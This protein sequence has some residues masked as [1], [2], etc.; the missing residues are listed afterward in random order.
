MALFNLKANNTS[1]KQELN[2]GLTTFFTMLYIVPVNALIMSKAGLPF[3]AL[4]TATAIFTMIATII[5]GLWSNTP[6]GLSVGMGLN[7]Y[8]TFG[9]VLG[10]KIP[11]E[12]A[13]GIV[14]ISALL[15]FI[16][17][18]TKFRIWIL[19]S[20]PVD[21]RRAI[22]AGIG[23]FIAF[24]G[25]Q[26]MGI[27]VK[28]DS[29]LITLGNLS[30]KH[31][32]I[33]IIG[34]VIVIVL[35][36]LKL[37]ASFIIAIALT[38]IIAF[39]FHLAPTPTHIV[40]LPAS[41][42]PIFLKLDIL[43]ALKLSFL[44]VIV[45]FFITHLFDSLGTLGGVGNRAHIFEDK[46]GAKKLERALQADSFGACLGSLGGLSTIT[47]FA[48]SASGVEAGARTGLAAVIAGLCFIA[49]LFFMP[50]FQAL[51]SNAIYP[52][53]IM[54]GILMFSELGKIDFSDIAVN[55]AGFGA[56]VMMPLTYSITNGLAFGFISYVIV[57]LVRRE[58]K[59]LNLGIIVLT[60]ISILIL[61]LHEA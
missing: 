56:V 29:T 3:E 4:L 40:S 51:P 55:I 8:F 37:R 49:T 20:I 39:I 35:F 47:V 34:L 2:G 54:V 17:S 45:I 32:I 14:F 59:A 26:Q 1:I 43:G 7:A 41:P 42:L 33:G 44:P 15:F 50:L 5:S 46:S 9:L 31:T 28:S 24:V 36:A 16:L 52:V 58:F 60:L 13:L 53:L 61:V 12:S 57:K 23:L 6:I 25:L 10:A 27:I 19:E 21:L 11:W 22:S 38:S 18:F 30:D 48:E